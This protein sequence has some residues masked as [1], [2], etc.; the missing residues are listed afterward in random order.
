MLSSSVSILISDLWKNG[1][2]F[3][4]ESFS[5]AQPPTRNLFLV[6]NEKYGQNKTLLLWCYGIDFAQLKDT[7]HFFW[8]VPLWYLSTLCLY[9]CPS[10]CLVVSPS[11][12]SFVG[13][14]FLSQVSCCFTLLNGAWPWKISD[15]V[16][17]LIMNN[18]PNFQVQVW[19]MIDTCLPVI[20]VA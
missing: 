7:T 10:V 5:P 13:L 15:L 17:I 16:F 6:S 19:F 14:S 20:L 2:R 18:T 11:V 8:I 1:H 12:C 4:L 9:I 3:T